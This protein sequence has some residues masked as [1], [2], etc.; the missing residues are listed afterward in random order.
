[1]PLRLWRRR[2]ISHQV[3]KPFKA[4]HDMISKRLHLVTTLKNLIALGAPLSLDKTWTNHTTNKRE[5]KKN[6]ADMCDKCEPWYI[7]FN[8]IRYDTK[9]HFTSAVIGRELYSQCRTNAIHIW[10]CFFVVLFVIFSFCFTFTIIIPNKV[11]IIIMMINFW[12]LTS[13][14]K[15]I[16]C[17]TLK[18]LII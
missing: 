18:H 16:R 5:C 14:F 13:S 4:W 1:M 6:K 10:M 17:H 15:L 8:T 12:P 7:Y 11:A 3:F 2:T 9:P